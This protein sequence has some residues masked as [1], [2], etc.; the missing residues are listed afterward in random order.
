MPTVTCEWGLAGIEAWAG[1]A[2]ALV[3]V[4]ILSF[5]TAVAVA[6]EAGAEVVPFRYGDPAAAAEEATRRNAL[7]AAPRRALGGQLTLSPASLRALAP[8]TRLVLPSPNGSR[9]SL[10]VG[11]VPTFCAGFRNAA[12]VAHAARA[13]AGEGVVAVIAAGERW[14]DRSLRPAIEDWLGAGAVIAALD[15]TESAEASLARIAHDAVADR[16]AAL[17]GDSISGCELSGSGFAA[18][19]ALALERDVSDIAPWLCDGAYR[20]FDPALTPSRRACP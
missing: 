11:A 14:P 3:I 10:A 4:D 18:D 8:G 5:S 12:A 6:L 17:I 15:G 20:R 7:A 19:I 16:L 13:I 1:R 2:A 9:L